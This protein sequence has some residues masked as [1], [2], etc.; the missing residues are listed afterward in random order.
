MK[1]KKKILF[2][3]AYSILVIVI[4]GGIGYAV[5]AYRWKPIHK[6]QRENIE[7]LEKEAQK[8]SKEQVKWNVPIEQVVCVY[9][10]GTLDFVA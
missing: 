4:A 2:F 7:R 3:I 6:R 9:I 1:R 5:N 10:N 8:K